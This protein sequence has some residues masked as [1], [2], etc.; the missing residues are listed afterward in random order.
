MAFL[1]GLVS[2]LATA[3]GSAFI[4]CSGRDGFGGMDV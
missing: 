1:G 4:Y 2:W 3:L